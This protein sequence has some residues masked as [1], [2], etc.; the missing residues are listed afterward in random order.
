MH[1]QSRRT[2]SGHRT[3]FGCCR[4]PWP[5]GLRPGRAWPP[6][7]ASSAPCPVGAPCAASRAFRPGG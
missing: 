2:G 6:S 5:R 4:H 1:G 7:P 3:G